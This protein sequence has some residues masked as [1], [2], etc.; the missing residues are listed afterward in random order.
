MT[1][2]QRETSLVSL[3]QDILGVIIEKSDVQTLLHLQ[4]TSKLFYRICNDYMNLDAATRR[5]FH[6]P[7]LYK[8]ITSPRLKENITI[9][10]TALTFIPK[11][12]EDERT[13]TSI[14]QNEFLIKT[15]FVA[16]TILGQQ[17]LA[18]RIQHH[19]PCTATVA[20]DLA[21]LPEHFHVGSNPI[22]FGETELLHLFPFVLKTCTECGS[23]LLFFEKRFQQ[24]KDLILRSVQST[25]EILETI[26][27]HIKDDPVFMLEAIRKNGYAYNYA[28]DRLKDNDAFV[29]SICKFDGWLALY[30]ASA[31]IRNLDEIVLQATTQNQNA[32]SFASSRLQKIYRKQPTQRPQCTIL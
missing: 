32:I 3:P 5:I 7:K 11:L 19:N 17:E 23:E 13:P 18:R 29:L 1:P 27:P 21:I 25:P 12:I 22:P 6:T 20:R 24:N 4:A 14:K 28:S 15:A 8:K 2:I 16:A 10:E 30:Y 26:S 31:R 9:A